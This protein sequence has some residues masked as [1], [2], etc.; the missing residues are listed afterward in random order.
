MTAPKQNDGVE[1]VALRHALGHYGDFER[2]G[3]PGHGDG[4]LRHVVAAQ[5]VK[6]AAEQ[7]RRDELVEA[8]AHDAHLHALV[9]Y[10]AF[11]DVDGHDGSSLLLYELGSTLNDSNRLVFHVLEQVPHAV[12]LG[13]QVTAVVLLGRDLDGHALGDLQVEAGK[14]VHLIGVVGEQA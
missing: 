5:R 13:L 10:L 2:A 11:D 12:R 14:A 9:D 3:N 4:L 8:G 6:R 7:L 1:L